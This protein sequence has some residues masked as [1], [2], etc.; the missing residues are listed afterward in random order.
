VSEPSENVGGAGRPARYGVEAE[1]ERLMRCPECGSRRVR[2]VR[3]GIGGGYGIMGFKAIA[4]FSSAKHVQCRNCGHEW[5]RPPVRELRREAERRIDER[6]AALDVENE[7]LRRQL[8][9]YLAYQRDVDRGLI[10]PPEPE[11]LVMGQGKQPK[12]MLSRS[13]RRGRVTCGT[14]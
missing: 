14:V 10:A 9:D 12:R 8:A 5:D 7:R 3:E 6:Y 13:T 1:I 11:P 4:E 2:Q